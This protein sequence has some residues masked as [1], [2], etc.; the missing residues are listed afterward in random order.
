MT[1][2]VVM[3]ARNEAPTVAANVA[4][5]LGCRHA[6]RVIV[7]DDGSTDGTADIAAA[8]GAHE[9]VRRESPS[10]SKA[11]AMARGLEKSDADAVLFVDADCVGL[12]AAHLDEICEPFV[13]G[14]ATM[15]V[16]CFDYGRLLNAVMLR[17]PPISGERVIPRW[18]FEEIPPEKLEG[19]TIETRINGVIARHREPTTVR[20]MSGVHHRTKRQKMGFVAGYRATLTMFVDLFRLAF[21]DV[22]VRSYWWYLRGLTVEQ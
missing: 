3:P 18:V 12:T 6:R 20:T 2:D 19:Y 11:R 7:V 14:R 13:E 16:G 10:G 15:S 4:A 9:V 1:I 8:A 22:P 17:C 5:A 21:G